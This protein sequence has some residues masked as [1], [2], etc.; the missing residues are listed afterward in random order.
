MKLYRI[1]HEVIRRNKYLE[2]VISP[3]ILIVLTA[4]LFLTSIS[5]SCSSAKVVELDSASYQATNAGD[6]LK[7]T[8]SYK[9]KY[10][11]LD[12]KVTN[13]CAGNG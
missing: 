3:R 12:G 5:L 11:S 7:N 8:D 6:L 13:A 4:L 1:G 10:V 2:R 9:G